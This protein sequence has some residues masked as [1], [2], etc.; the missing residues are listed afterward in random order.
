VVASLLSLA[1]VVAHYLTAALYTAWFLLEIKQRL[2]VWKSGSMKKG[3]FVDLRNLVRCH[4][5]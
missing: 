5:N 1:S 3:H 2:M 4:H